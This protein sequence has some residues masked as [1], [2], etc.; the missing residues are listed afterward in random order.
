MKESQ[1]R[2]GTYAINPS[3]ILYNKE[4]KSSEKMLYAMI[5]SLACKVI[6]RKIYLNDAP[7]PLNNRYMYPLNN[8]QAIQQNME[9]NIVRN[10]IKNNKN[11]YIEQRHYSEEFLNSLYANSN[12]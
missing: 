5:T 11:S 12:I 1:E 4:L 8:G 10:N 9:D 6:K 2:I 7:Y 3:T